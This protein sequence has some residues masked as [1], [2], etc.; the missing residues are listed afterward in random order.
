MLRVRRW[1][2]LCAESGR[3]QKKRARVGFHGRAKIF[4]VWKWAFVERLVHTYACI[5][6]AAASLLSLLLECPGTPWSWDARKGAP[7]Y[8]AGRGFRSQRERR[9]GLL[10]PRRKFNILLL[11]RHNGQSRPS[12]VFDQSPVRAAKSITMIIRRD[13]SRISSYSPPHPW[14]FLIIKSSGKIS[15][16]WTIRRGFDKVAKFLISVPISLSFYTTFFFFFFW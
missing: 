13:S 3:T 11:E 6:F 8:I 16:T 4:I 12:P 15:H 5:A 14:T 2:A 7:L 1:R 9:S 10:Q